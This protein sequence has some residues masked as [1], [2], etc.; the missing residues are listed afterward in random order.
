M[1]VLLLGGYGTFGAHAARALARTGVK[2]RIAGR[3]EARAQSFATSLGAGHEGIAADAADPASCARALAGA[4][5]AINCAGPFSTLPLT[6]PEACL[7]A[8][9]HYVDIADDR[10]WLV[11]LRALDG[12]FRDRGL[13]AA[14][15]CSSLPGIS[16]ALALL[17]AERLSAVH[18]ARV[19]L[20]IGN[21]NPKGDA[22]VRSAAAQL[23]KTF[24]SPQ[25]PLVG[26]RGRETVHLPEPF[27][28]RSVYDWNSPELDLF[29]SLLGTREVRVKVGFE[30]RLAM[31]A[32]ATL[33]RLGP[34]GSRLVPS[35][36]VLG[37]ALSGF[38]HS[39]GFV[40]VELFAPDGT[41]ATASLGGPKD[42]QRMAA[43][44]AAFVASGLLDGT[45][46]AQG[47]VTAYEALGAQRLIE[48]LVAEGYVL[49]RP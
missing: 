3:N 14:C 23:G 19:T 8:G 40:Q 35:L 27:G 25:G 2:I 24:S 32:F 17:A 21:R 7:T 11:R 12:H 26:L 49:L 10:S 33:A 38:G 16:G 31:S 41:T 18:R 29:P 42:G 47:V 48:A 5:V 44:P 6:L 4:R 46:T 43:L 30:S 20:F 1:T 37:R 34:L 36:A 28:D 15:G 9:A 22:A 39:G 13:T 45:V